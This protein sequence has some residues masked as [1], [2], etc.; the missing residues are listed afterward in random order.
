MVLAL[1]H[2]LKPAPTAEEI[3]R[4]RFVSGLRGF[5]L[6][7]LAADLRKAWDGRAKSRFE[8]WAQRPAADGRDVHA[9]LRGD[10]AFTCYS[11]LRVQAQ[12]LV[13]DSVGDIVDR[14]REAMAQKITQTGALERV[15]LKDDF[16]A[17][18]NVTAI[19]V[20]L[21]PGSYTGAHGKTDPGPGAMY[22]QGLAVFSFGLMGE[23]LDDIGRSM[24]AYVSKKWPDFT[25]KR[26]L[27]LGC[28]I[29]HNTLP[30]KWT[31]PEAEVIGIDAAAPGLVYGAARA[32]LQDADVRFMEMD[33]SKLA[34]EDESFD[35]VFTSMFLHELSLKTIGQVF[36]EIRRVLKPGGMMLHM[37]LPPNT[38]M[39]PFESF[40]LDWDC[41]Y[42][43]EPFYK[44]FRDQ[45]PKT[46]VTKAGFWPDAYFQ[47]VVPSV[48]GYGMEAVEHAVAADSH[49]VD[50][51][52][53]GR[54][55]DGI[56][57]FGFGAW[58]R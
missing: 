48:G 10:P 12:K 8:A 51:E 40:Y 15:T 27:D 55:A 57:W 19:D 53:T 44:A 25:P 43:E 17:P 46:L 22:D 6:N 35:L 9:A 39:S 23:N 21:M 42:N 1:K 29:G 4:Q 58:K 36:A 24:S 41:Y 28:T 26:I 30:W 33:A 50:K 5:V 7:D 37:E 54:L 49:D 3:A 45:D 2:D 16:T 38:Q 14:E 52:T 32:K 11:A 18:R 20:H 47:F 31:Y 34:F 56:Q 13:W